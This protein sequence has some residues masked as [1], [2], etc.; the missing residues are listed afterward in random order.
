MGRLV[1]ADREGRPWCRRVERG[2][3]CRAWCGTRCARDRNPS[4]QRTRLHPGSRADAATRKL[5]DK[6]GAARRLADSGKSQMDALPA[7][8]NEVEIGKV[9]LS[10]WPGIVGASARPF[11]GVEVTD[12]MRA[13][14]TSFICNSI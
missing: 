10:V 12:E 1:G 8:S 2:S 3:G 11:E 7:G 5:I 6:F 13:A 4:A 14:D 9:Q